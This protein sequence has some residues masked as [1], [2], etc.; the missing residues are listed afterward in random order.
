MPE[1]KQVKNRTRLRI[2]GFRASGVSC[3][4]KKAGAKDLAL[5][6]SDTEAEVAGVFTK[7]RV[8]AAPVLL[9]ME[10]VKKGASRGVVVNS[11]NANVST[12]A[13]GLSNALRMASAVE[14][15]MGVRSGGIL[16]ASTGVIGVMPAIEK[17]EAG[18]PELIRALSADGF[19]DAASA[20]MTTDAF[21]KTAMASARIKGRA[22]TIAGI[23]KGAGM[24]CPDMATM[25]SFIMTDANIKHPALSRALKEAVDR[26]FNSIAVDN[27]TSTNDTVLIF[28]N[29]VS[30]G[31]EIKAG[32]VEFKAFCSLLNEVTL[33]LAHLIVK[34]GEGAT[35]FIEIDI[36]GAA[37]VNDAKKA[38]R[39]LAASMLVKTAFFGADPN[40]GRI[41]AA[42]GR[43]GIKM[44]EDRVDIT[45]NNVPVAERG[46][47][48][49]KEKE[50]ANAMKAKEVNMTVTL[51][52]GKAAWRFWTTDLTYEYVKI[53]SAY[54]T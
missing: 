27:D 52:M 4:L 15:G 10:R 51:G 18:A 2:P 12:G 9:D 21:A 7:N 42:L 17:I 35:K 23:A 41:M 47:D 6:M 19:S 25:L 24:I 22:V 48:T 53:N 1:K 26:S 5:I 8:K 31:R 13:L 43:A 38:A 28:A 36:K 3:G 39:T 49:G 34:D 20:I 54:R 16:V 11:G 37:T 46:V 32:R 29:G 40:W 33:K 45:L 30:G 44:K 14:K 50:A